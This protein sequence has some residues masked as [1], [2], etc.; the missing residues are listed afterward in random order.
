MEKLAHTR[1]RAALLIAVFGSIIVFNGVKA[2]NLDDEY[3]DLKDKFEELNRTVERQEQIIKSLLGDD[4]GVS[5]EP[6]PET[7]NPS[8]RTTE[9]L[10]F[11]ENLLGEDRIK[12]GK[13]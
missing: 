5:P 13:Q 2:D 4:S 6:N 11:N 12:K 8:P 10:L 7:I 3:R 1:L 9:D